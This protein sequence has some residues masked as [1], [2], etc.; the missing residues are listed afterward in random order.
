MIQKVG[1]YVFF[2][3]LFQIVCT[4]KVDI[5]NNSMVLN[6]HF[7]SMWEHILCLEELCELGS[8]FLLFTLVLG[9]L[10]IQ[11]KTSFCIIFF[12]L[13]KE[14]YIEFQ[15]SFLSKSNSWIIL[16]SKINTHRQQ[17]NPL[18]DQGELL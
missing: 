9:I 7:S 4:R 14:F 6:I 16:M 8:K 15:N 12:K 18:N 10:L 3:F 5:Y 2:H 17:Q 11:D 1:Q 13:L